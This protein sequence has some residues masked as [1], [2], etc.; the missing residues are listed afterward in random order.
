M[1]HLRKILVALFLILFWGAVW[2]GTLTYIGFPLVYDGMRSAMLFVHLSN[3]ALLF[4]LMLRSTTRISW[5]FAN[6]FTYS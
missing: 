3:L 4:T 5:K 1:K 2:T 6:P